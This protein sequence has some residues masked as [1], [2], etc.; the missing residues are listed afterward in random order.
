MS[1]RPAISTARSPFY[2]GL[3]GW[4]KSDAID[5]GPMGTYQIF[6]IDDVQAGGMRTKTPQMPSL[7]IKTL[8]EENYRAQF[9]SGR[10]GA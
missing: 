6:N 3:F 7:V 2:S 5:K 9:F 8:L 1:C 4:T 10:Q